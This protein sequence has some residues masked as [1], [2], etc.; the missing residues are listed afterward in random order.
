MLLHK[1]IDQLVYLDVQ[2]YSCEKPAVD[3]I[4]YVI[5]WLFIKD[6]YEL[7]FLIRTTEKKDLEEF[8][9]ISVDKYLMRWQGTNLWHQSEDFYPQSA[10]SCNNRNMIHPLKIQVQ[11]KSIHNNNLN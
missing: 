10:Y 5:D 8:V 3:I 9:R 4:G 1:L 6:E 2:I 11:Y 7:G